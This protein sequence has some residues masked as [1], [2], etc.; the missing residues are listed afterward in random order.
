MKI[1]SFLF[2]ALFALLGLT[3]CDKKEKDIGFDFGQNFDLAFD[4]TAISTDGTVEIRF[5]AV[6]SDSR[7]P[8]DVVCVW[9][10]EA[11]IALTVTIASTTADITLSTHPDFGQVDTL[12]QHVFTLVNLAPYPV[13]TQG[14]DEDDYTAEL[15]VE[16]L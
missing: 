6:E 7:C 12:D 16:K 3:S 2:L 5:K 1:K 15:R 8:S 13:S 9:E 4:E 10:G 11:T 14:Y